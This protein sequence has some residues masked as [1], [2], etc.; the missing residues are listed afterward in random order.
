LPTK[1]IAKPL[2]YTLVVPSP[3]KEGEGCTFGSAPK[4]STPGRSII[5]EHAGAYPE[6]ERAN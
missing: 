1:R 5:M 3:T 4:P 2:R 6:G